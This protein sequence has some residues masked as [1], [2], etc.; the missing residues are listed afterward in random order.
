MT[1]AKHLMMLGVSGAALLA[2][3]NAGAATIVGGSALLDAAYANQLES[4]LGQGPV[5]LTNIFTKTQGSTSLDFHAAADG[6][7]PTFAVMRAT[8]GGVTAIIGGYNPQ[9]WNSISAYNI[10]VD[11]ADR[12]AFIFNLTTNERRNQTGAQPG[13]EIYQT[14]NILS[15]GP[16][17]GGGHDIWVN[18]A[19]SA[20]YSFG[21]SY[22]TPVNVQTSIVTN[23][24]YYL[25]YGFSIAELEIFSISPG[26]PTK[27]PA[28]A[29]LA[30]LGLGLAGLGL[31]AR[32]RR[33][34]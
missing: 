8:E 5:T 17:F 29:S 6:Q 20:G 33:N 23:Q 18:S 27:V 30:L 34:A 12:T 28:P 14:Y 13:L 15:Y 2:A 9:S 1:F 24:S 10:T 31:V 19:L 22:G 32:R 16:T 7:G 26:E 11:P 3:G 25:Y 21:W 4:W